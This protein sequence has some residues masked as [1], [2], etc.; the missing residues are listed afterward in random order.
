MDDLRPSHSVSTSFV[1]RNFSPAEAVLGKAQHGVAMKRAAREPLN[2][3]ESIG[4]ISPI[5]RNQPFPEESLA[6]KAILCLPE[7]GGKPVLAKQPGS[8]ALR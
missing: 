8:V 6:A 7:R 5:R 4:M 1:L 2:P 3:V